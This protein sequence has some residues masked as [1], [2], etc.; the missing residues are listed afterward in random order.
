MVTLVLPSFFS[1]ISQDDTP[2]HIKWAAMTNALRRTVATHNRNLHTVILALVSLRYTRSVAPRSVSCKD[3]GRGLKVHCPCAYV[4]NRSSIL[5]N[6]NKVLWWGGQREA[7]LTNYRGDNAHRFTFQD[8]GQYKERS[9]GQIQST[10]VT[11][12]CDG[13]FIL[14]AETF[15]GGDSMVNCLMLIY[16]RRLTYF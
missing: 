14:I 15:C 9:P 13:S 12:G 3:P 1:L 8:P 5:V 16:V 11:M 4:I 6:A 10:K 7:R 2:T